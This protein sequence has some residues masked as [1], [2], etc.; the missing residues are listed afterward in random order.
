MF[1]CVS[2]K[3]HQNKES[4][5]IQ[6]FHNSTS[7][8][9][10]LNLTTYNS[11]HN[12][13]YCVAKSTVYFTFCIKNLLRTLYKNV[14]KVI[15]TNTSSVWLQK[16][17]DLSLTIKYSCWSRHNITKNCSNVMVILAIIT[18]DSSLEP[19]EGKPYAITFC[20]LERSVSKQGGGQKRGGTW[21]RASEYSTDFTCYYHFYIF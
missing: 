8:T 18:S 19:F 17:G 20:M 14:M 4:T 12:V 10:L 7:S 5:S 6:N 21:T 9:R 13:Y 1:L 11:P 3:L 2:A 15:A 16:A